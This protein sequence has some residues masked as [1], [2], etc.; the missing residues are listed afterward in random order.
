MSQKLLK[1]LHEYKWSVLAL[2]FILGALL[3]SRGGLMA[4]VP[5]IRFLF[6][7]LVLILLFRL[8]KGRLSAAFGEQLRKATEQQRET[9]RQQMGGGA[10]PGGHDGNVIDLCPKC[11]S[12]LKPGHRCSK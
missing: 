2:V 9:M 4:L 5:V 6:P 10:G 8:I 3:E 1:K 11:G 7:V 12:Y